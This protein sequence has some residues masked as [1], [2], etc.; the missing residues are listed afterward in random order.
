VADRY[1]IFADNGE[2]YDIGSN[3]RTHM[4]TQIQNGGGNVN[5]AVSGQ[6]KKPALPSTSATVVRLT[7]S[8][9]HNMTGKPRATSGNIALDW[10]VHRPEANGLFERFVCLLRMTQPLAAG[11]FI[12]GMFLLT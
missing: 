12:P 7:A 9:G 5:P 6:L 3:H 1:G 8:V 2:S 4:T 11:A 10:Q